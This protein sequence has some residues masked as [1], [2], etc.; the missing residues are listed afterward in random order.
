L[1]QNNKIKE[2]DDFII[3]SN[4]RDKQEF[5]AIFQ[6]GFAEKGGVS[7]FKI[8]SEKIKNQEAKVK[9]RW[10]YKNGGSDFEIIPMRIENGK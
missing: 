1:I 7:R 9:I 8:E 6:G 4:P 10:Y 3:T 5:A 2:L